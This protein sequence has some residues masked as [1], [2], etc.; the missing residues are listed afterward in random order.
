MFLLG[1]V[2]RCPFGHI[3]QTLSFLLKFPYKQTKSKQSTQTHLVSFHK[4]TKSPQHDIKTNNTLLS[5]SAAEGKVIKRQGPAEGIAQETRAACKTEF[6]ND[7]SQML[8][9]SH[10]QNLNSCLTPP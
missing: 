1:F 3:V 8:G 4:C 9:K 6:N 2:F 10:V 7:Y 5:F